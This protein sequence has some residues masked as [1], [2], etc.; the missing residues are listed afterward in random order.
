MIHNIHFQPLLGLRSAHAQTV[1]AHFLKPGTAPDST[2]LIVRL[3]DND[4]LACE[5]ATPPSWQTTQKTVLMI[6][7]LGGSHESNYM[8]RL[9]RKLYNNGIRTIRINLRGCGSGE[10]LA[11]K[12]YHA[13][14]SN[15]ILQVIRKVHEKTPIS[16]LILIGFSLGGNIVLK[17]AG[18]QGA[19]INDLVSQTIAICPPIDLARTYKRLCCSINQLYHRHYLRYIRIQARHLLQGKKIDSIHD[20]DIAV[21]VPQWGFSNAEEYYK[22][23]SSL[24][25]IPSIEHPCSILF[26]ADDPFIEYRDITNC[27]LPPSVKVYVSNRGGHMGFFGWAGPEHRYHWLDHMIMKWISSEPITPT[28]IFHKTL[29]PI[30][31]F[32]P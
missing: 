17:L 15:D 12:S 1:F 21:T 7:G 5:I 8:I 29:P 13:G 28:P 30:Q 6:H 32:H 10:G 4:R 20:F 23:C 25:L 16:P 26:A 19:A 3:E 11:R 24:P 9:S 2:S 14:V 27:T 18:E 22:T 31:M